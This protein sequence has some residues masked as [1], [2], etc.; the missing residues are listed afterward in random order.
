MDFFD[1]FNN[2]WY[3]NGLEFQKNMMNQYMDTMN[4]LGSLAGGDSAWQKQFQE[5]MK[6]WMDLY[7][8]AFKMKDGL[9]VFPFGKDMGDAAKVFDK[10][11][12]SMSIYTKLQ[13]IWVDF[14]GE[15]ATNPAEYFQISQK[16]ITRTG[17]LIGETAKDMWKPF[18]PEDMFSIIDSFESVGR[19]ADEAYSEFMAPW[20]DNKEELSEYFNKF[21]AGDLQSSGKY[22]SLLTKVYQDSFGKLFHLGSVGLFKDQTELNFTTFDSYVKFMLSFIEMMVSVQNIL[23]D[24]NKEFWSEITRLIED[25]ETSMTFKDFYEMWIKVNA[26]AINDF[27]FTDECAEFIGK[28]VDSASDFRIKYNEFVESLFGNLP[29]PTDSEMKSVYKTVYDLRKEIRNLKKEIKELHRDI[30]E[31]KA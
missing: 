19:N 14:A 3:K 13:A 27:Y 30:D 17:E 28:F 31:I 22:I 4:T 21:M 5:N 1:V 2:E 18:I 20:L 25:S 9:S 6:K 26:K 10:F 11:M 23:N 12:N 8:D 15:I 29:I 7:A 16:Y 24:A